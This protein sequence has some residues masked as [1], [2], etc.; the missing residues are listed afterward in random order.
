[1]TDAI[2]EGS[3]HIEPPRLTQQIPLRL[4]AASIAI[5]CVAT[6]SFVGYALYEKVS[7]VEAR[8][9]YV[10]TERERILAL[11]GSDMTDEIRAVMNETLE[12][13]SRPVM[14]GRF[15]LVPGA[16]D[17]GHIFSGIPSI[18][19]E[20]KVQKTVFLLDTSCGDVWLYS[21]SYLDTKDHR[22]TPEHF[23]RIQNAELSSR[24]Q[25]YV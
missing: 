21:P 8:K 19:S 25:K 12:I 14:P 22:Y 3:P 18:D 7:E 16:V 24:F 11:V 13:L 20:K 15:Q 1:M 5:L 10:A 17:E 9:T 4:I 2:Q 23:S 6:S